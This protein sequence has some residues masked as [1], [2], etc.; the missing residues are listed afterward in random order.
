M[1]N[2][3]ANKPSNL[4]VPPLRIVINS[5]GNCN[6]NSSTNNS[7]VHSGNN[8]NDTSGVTTTDEISHPSDKSN[9]EGPSTSTKKLADTRQ[10]TN[11][12]AGLSSN[13]RES[14]FKS[15]TFK[16]NR[17]SE[18]S[19][20]TTHNGTSTPIN[21]TDNIYTDSVTSAGASFSPPPSSD[22]HQ[23]DSQGDGATNPTAQNC[24]GVRYN[25]STDSSQKDH[26]SSSTVTQRI[27]RSSQRAAQQTKPDNQP[28]QQQMTSADDQVSNSEN[29]DKG[30][31]QSRKL[32]R[33]KGDT[34]EDD[35]NSPESSASSNTSQQAPIIYRPPAQNSFQLYK[36]IRM[37]VDRRLRSL[38]CV[39][40]R[41][42]HGFKDYLLN[43]GAY[44][45]EGAPSTGRNNAHH[46]G[47]STSNN[48][49]RSKGTN[50][51]FHKNYSSLTGHKYGSSATLSPTSTLGV[52]Q[53]AKA[54][55]S[56]VVGSAL[57]SL[58]IEQEKARH[59]MRMQH[60]KEREKLTLS[61]EQEILRV[62]NQA[63]LAAANQLE[64]FSVCTLLKHEEIY[65]YIEP[66]DGTGDVIGQEEI[67]QDADRDLYNKKI[68]LGRLQDIDDKWEQIKGQM[69]ARHIN[70]ADSLYAFQ[71]LEWEWRIKETGAC[72]LWSTPTIEPVHVP[73]VDVISINY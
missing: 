63:A 61:A 36:N 18:S 41:T 7:A 17:E 9:T 13:P 64:P 24:N 4:K 50:L 5:S 72:D 71:K 1:A 3:D 58:F 73:K 54:P 46:A 26:P 42:P 40:P 60:I 48:D 35:Q 19:D 22:T 12:G 56:L 70:E 68:F 66:S 28:D 34:P 6:A 10:T 37:Q 32:K 44:L 51:Q 57:H 14:V 62:Y 30:N 29:T 23:G 69:L 16:V 67:L 38:N 43:R 33:R 53:L 52:P 65:N 8:S 47:S 2:D 20:S 15:S 25:Y 45:L 21:D 39:H 31:E 27:T 11:S 59:K 55:E 49:P